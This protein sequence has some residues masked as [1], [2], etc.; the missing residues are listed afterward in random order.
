MIVVYRNLAFSASVFLVLLTSAASPAWTI[1]AND[2]CTWGVANGDL[3]IPA[4]SIPVGAILTLH[5]VSMDSSVPDPTLNIHLL[6]NPEPGIVKLTGLSACDPFAGCGTSLGAFSQLPMS[7]QDLVVDLAQVNDLQS[8]IWSVFSNPYTQTMG[9]QDAVTY[10]SALLELMNYSGSGRSFGFGFY[11]KGFVCSALTLQITIQ[12]LTDASLPQ[13]ITFSTG[14]LHAPQL[15]AIPDYTVTAAQILTFAVTGSDGDGDAPLLY[16]ADSLPQGA[17]FQDQ[18]FTWTPTSTQAGTWQILFGISDG[19]LNGSQAVTITV[20]APS[21]W[22]PILYDNFESGM[23]NWIDGGANCMRYVGSSHAHQGSGA[24]N[25]QDNSSS[26]VASTNNLALSGYSA[27]KVEFWYKCISMDGT[28]EDFWL[29]ISTNG[30]STYT[31]VEEWNLNDE[32]INGQFYQDSVTITGHTLTNQ[33]RLRF[34]C[35]ASAKDDD[36]YIDQITVSVK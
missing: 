33:T 4:G 17:S 23:G 1:D 36:V 25:L 6:H 32:F 20:N 14:N 5:N 7:G 9:N 19:Q 11:S 31:T 26:S 3:S 34:R 24:L 35:D 30:G 27:I 8:P 2:S 16:W 12:S 15:Q 10:S 22:N 18:Q 13:I 29:Q 28:S 21:A